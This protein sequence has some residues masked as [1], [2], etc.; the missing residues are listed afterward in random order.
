MHQPFLTSRALSRRSVVSLGV[1]AACALGSSPAAA[2]GHCDV[3]LLSC[4]DY[5]LTGDIVR[6][7]DGRG[8]G[9]DYDH[10]VLAGA[11]LGA[12]TRRRPAWRPTFWQHL[13]AAV[14]LHQIKKVMVLDHRDCGAYRLF[15]G[16]RAVDTPEKEH[17][18]HVAELRRLR[19][20]INARRRGLEVELGLMALD[21]SVETIA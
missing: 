1:C 19:Q 8:L 7:M 11:A 9:G 13:D 18:A 14:S 12:Q 21:G 10:V 3:M 16:E 20:Q 4:M 5:R 2:A 6:Y 15:L 17:A